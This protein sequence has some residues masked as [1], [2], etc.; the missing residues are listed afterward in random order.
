MRLGVS[1]WAREGE[2]ASLSDYEDRVLHLL[3]D[4]GGAV[5]CRVRPG[6]PT[7]IQLLDVPSG[8]ALAGFMSDPRRAALASIRERA[9]ARTRVVQLRTAEPADEGA[10]R[11][12]HHR[13]SY[14]WSED[15]AHL[16]AHP[17]VFG[18]AEGAIEAGSTRVACGH[19]GRI[20]G[21]ATLLDRGADANVLEDLF[22]DPGE[23]R[24]GIGRILVEDAASRTARP[25]SVIAQERTRRFYERAGFVLD[26]AAQTRFGPALRLTRAASA[27]SP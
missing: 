26:G 13:A 19:D 2:A 16:D 17:E 14:I 4:H 11:E 9:I 23:M 12:L 25:I 5:V 18:V 8:Q 20:V 1:L 15:R 24:A 10:L 3:P 22:V 27:T 21:F 6:I 7:E